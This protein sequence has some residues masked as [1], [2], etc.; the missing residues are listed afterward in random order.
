MSKGLMN[1]R[2]LGGRNWKGQAFLK[3]I[4]EAFENG[5]SPYGAIKLMMMMFMKAQGKNGYLASSL[6]KQCT[7]F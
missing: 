4:E 2:I 5:L 1:V 7:L 6:W 3:N